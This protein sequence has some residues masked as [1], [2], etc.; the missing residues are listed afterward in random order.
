MQTPTKERGVEDTHPSPGN[1]V[2]KEL[3]MR[4]VLHH[5]IDVGWRVNHL[6]AE[7][8]SQQRSVQ[9]ENIKQLTGG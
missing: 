7:T 9:T 4:N 3:A 5:G 6:V 8:N 1:N 2:V